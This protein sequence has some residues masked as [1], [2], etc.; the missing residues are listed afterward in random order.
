M[1]LPQE[2]KD[3]MSKFMLVLAILVLLAVVI[4]M[5]SRLVTKFSGGESETADAASRAL[6]AERLAPVASVKAG[7]KVTGPIV[8]SA[9]EIYDGVCAACHA[10]GAAGAPKVGDKAAWAPRI[11]QGVNTLVDHAIN[12]F[13]GMPA[14]GTDPTL[15]DDDIKKTIEFMTSKSK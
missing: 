1:S 5:V 9:Q 6:V 8:R 2:D 14:R 10:S 15:T 7:P 12:G 11:A 3:V 4:F 13:K